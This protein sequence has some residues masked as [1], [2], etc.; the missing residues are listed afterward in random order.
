[1]KYKTLPSAHVL[2]VFLQGLLHILRPLHLD[3]SLARGLPPVIGAEVD[4]VRALNIG[5]EF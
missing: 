2:L 3:E 4:P 5:E 1:M